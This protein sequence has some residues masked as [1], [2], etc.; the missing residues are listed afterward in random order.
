MLKVIQFLEMKL[1]RNAISS[2]Q[3]LRHQ[4]PSDTC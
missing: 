3:D 1:V 4:D 2:T